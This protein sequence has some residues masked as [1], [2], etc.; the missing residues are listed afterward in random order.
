MTAEPADSDP[1]GPAPET[2]EALIRSRLAHA[3]GGWRG[4]VEAG[5]PTVAYVVAWTATK[6]VRTAVLVS[7]AVVLV[8][9]GLRLAQRSTVQYALSAVLPTAIAAWF[10]LRSGRAQD[11][12]LGGILWSAALGAVTLV[13]VVTRFPLVGFLVGAADPRAAEDPFAWRRDP[14][15]VRVCSRLTWVLVGVYVV[16]LGIMVPLYLA[17]KVTALGVAKLVLG[18]PL[19]ALSVLVMGWLLLRGHTPRTQDSAAAIRHGDD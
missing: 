4:A 1:R 18:W 19:W 10:S 3:L 11:A 16:R 17:E 2:V 5:L 14:G 12:F 7:A 9:V 8:L 15:L 13:S 6:D